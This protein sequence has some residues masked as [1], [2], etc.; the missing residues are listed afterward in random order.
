M[1]PPLPAC[2]PTSPAPGQPCRLGNG[3]N[4]ADNFFNASIST[5]TAAPFHL[6]DP[7]YLNQFG[8]DADVMDA[9]G[10]LANGQD[11]TTIRLDTNGDGYAPQAISF[12][13]DLFAPSLHVVKAVDHDTARSG[14]ALTYTVDVSNVGLD[15]ATNT[16]LRDIIPSGT[17]YVPGSM[18]IDGVGKS[19]AAGDD[20]AEFDATAKTAVMRI[21]DGANATTG[22]R[23]AVGAPATRISFR[24]S[25]NPGLAR[26][27][28]VRNKA[29]VGYVSETL[30]QP[31]NVA[32][33]D[34]LTRILVP[35]LAIAKSHTGEFVSGKSVPFTLQVSSVGDVATRGLVTV[36][37][38]L[39]VVMSFVPPRPA[40]DGWTCSTTG[41]ALTCTRSDELAPGVVVPPIRYTARV[42]SGAPAGQVINTA[43]VA[44]DEDTNPANDVDEDG[45]A[46]R[47]PQIDLAIEKVALDPT[48]FPGDEVRF[49]LTVSN[50]GP[51][52]AT[53]VLVRELVPPGLTLTSADPSRGACGGSAVNFSCLVGRLRAGEQFTIDLTA[54]TGADTGGRTLVNRAVVSG[55]QRDINLANNSDRAE[56]QV[57]PLVDI[58][59]AKST[60]ASQIE[61]GGNATFLVVVRND[62]PSDATGVVLRDFLPTELTPVSATPTQGTCETPVSCTLGAIPAGGAAQIVVVASSD[63]SLAGRTVTNTAAAFATEKDSDLANNSDSAPVTFVAPPPLPA[64]VVVTKTASSQIVN[65]GDTLTY[66]VTARNRGPGPAENVVVTDTPHPSLALV[67]AVPSQGTCTPAVP[68]ELQPGNPGRG[69]L[70]DRPGDRPRPRRWLPAERRHRHHEHDDRHSAGRSRRRGR[71]HR[72][73]RPAGR[74]AQTRLTARGPLRRHGHVDADGHRARARDRPQH[75]RLRSPTARLHRRVSRRCG[76]AQRPLVLDDRLA[77][78]GV[79]AIAATGHAR[80]LGRV[81]DA[82][83]ERRDARVRRSGAPLRPCPRGDR[84]TGSAVHR[85]TALR[86]PRC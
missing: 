73:I 51:D 60:A 26:G 49:K 15:A 3:T 65:V 13:T 52:T 14:D 22:G 5:R 21:G 48:V 6:K 74:A 53:R 12:A 7:D 24:V 76:P 31:G 23:V 19:D 18:S 84:A 32:S 56:V 4:P 1:G 37:D 66:T 71:H 2:T 33:S 30:G 86:D 42:A 64:D 79:I 68:G 44:N 35:D 61:A 83:D 59:V 41:R 28:V 16:T 45:G 82:A 67:S 75:Q 69:R 40:G 8:F 25:V 20:Q 80:S 85:L 70:R 11:A 57:I 81:A 34:V 62:G 55:R 63:A 50:H 47:P 77:R 17:T 29:S 46:N 54:V 58:V 36:T 10:R 39:P 38:T 78:G 9:T 43:R 27:Y 72:P